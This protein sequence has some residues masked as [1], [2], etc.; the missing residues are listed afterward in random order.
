[1]LKIDCRKNKK[2]KKLFK[3][4][5]S[6]K[7]LQTTW[8]CSN[9]NTIDRL[10]ITDHGPTHIQIVTNRVLKILR[11]LIESKVKLSVVEYH[12]LTN[13][14]AEVIAVLTA[15]MHDLGISIHR[16]NHEEYSLILADRFL[17]KILPSLYDDTNRTIVKSEVLHGIIA[18][19]K[20]SNAYTI[21]AGIVKLADALDMEKGRARIPFKIGTVNIHS[22]SAMAIESVSIEKG[23]KR[24]VRIKIKMSNSAGIF[25]IDELLRKKLKKNPIRDYVS[26][27]VD[28]GEKEKK[29]I[30][31]LELD[32]D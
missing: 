10:G 20:D 3:V 21:E 1:M 6:D 17:D 27:V 15:L 30:K 31:I 2:L 9:I 16:D 28:T 12:G 13:D 14:D 25:Q 5:N 23:K 4:I 8:K 11:L 24:P 26:V 32:W 22:V 7:E 19:S 29:I 18:H